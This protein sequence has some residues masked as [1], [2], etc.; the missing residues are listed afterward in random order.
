MPSSAAARA[1]ARRTLLQGSSASSGGS[2]TPSVA[3]ETR[4]LDQALAAYI[5]AATALGATPQEKAA[6][7]RI[8]RDLKVLPDGSRKERTQMTLAK[9]FRGT[10]VRVTE[11][12]LSGCEGVV[13][14]GDGGSDDGQRVMVK[15]TLH[16]GSPQELPV[17]V[18]HLQLIQGRREAEEQERSA[19]EAAEAAA[20][21]ERIRRLTHAHP[22]VVLGGLNE[23]LKGKSFAELRLMAEKLNAG[24]LL[25][26][27]LIQ[28][29]RASFREALAEVLMRSEDGAQGLTD[30]L[31]SAAHAEAEEAHDESSMERAAGED[32][33]LQDEG[34]ETESSSTSADEDSQAEAKDAPSIGPTLPESLLPGVAS[35]EIAQ[36]PVSCTG[37]GLELPGSAPVEDDGEVLYGPVFCPPRTAGIGQ[38]DDGAARATTDV[39][40]APASQVCPTSPSREIGPTLW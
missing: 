21:E 39:D 23:E 5:A 35:L 15:L 12:R 30:L 33:S 10:R 29:D 24:E 36:Q 3:S 19:A 11:Q 16:D 14:A 13:F 7:E 8:Q 32:Q 37:P 31:L 38:P 40:E 18:I 17:K 6:I 28:Y 22:H 4:L 27:P 34:C 20:L 2:S 1:L 9:L 26:N 25:Y